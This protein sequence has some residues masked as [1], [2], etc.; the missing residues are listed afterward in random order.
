MSTSRANE[1]PKNLVANKMFDLAEKCVM[2]YM[3][4]ALKST[5]EALFTNTDVLSNK[6]VPLILKPIETYSKNLISLTIKIVPFDY[7]CNI[8]ADLLNHDEINN[9]IGFI[10]HSISTVYNSVLSNNIKDESQQLLINTSTHLEMDDGALSMYPIYIYP[11]RRKEL[12][13]LQLRDEIEKTLSQ[14]EA[15]N[16]SDDVNKMI[17]EVY[18]QYDQLVVLIREINYNKEVADKIEITNNNLNKKVIELALFLLR[19]IQMN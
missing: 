8:P 18:E 3:L 15:K 17:K 5:P 7:E 2:E 14:L 9:M 19:F 13:F 10:Y 6:T 1:T 16:E 4:D 11:V 12:M